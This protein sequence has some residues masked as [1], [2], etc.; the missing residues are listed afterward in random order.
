MEHVSFYNLEPAPSIDITCEF[1][2]VWWSITFLVVRWLPRATRSPDTSGRRRATSSGR[3]WRTGRSR[4]SRPTSTANSREQ[5]WA[6][7]WRCGWCCWGRGFDSW[8]SAKRIQT[9]PLGSRGLQ[10]GCGVTRWFGQFRQKCLKFC[11]TVNLTFLPKC[12]KVAQNAKFRH[13]W[14]H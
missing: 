8:T 2:E 13:I 5:G 12:K 3:S 6:R 11:Q 10:R 7:G 14:P 1:R 4:K 9:L